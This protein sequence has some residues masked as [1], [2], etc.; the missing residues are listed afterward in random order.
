MIFLTR[1]PVKGNTT[2]ELIYFGKS[3]SA[4]DILIYV[5]EIGAL[6]TGDLFSRYG[7][8]GFGGTYTTDKKRWLNAHSWILKRTD[9]IETIIDGH[10]QIL[11]IDDLRS[12]NKSLLK[13]KGEEI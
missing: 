8:P 1:F 4:S 10:G 3:H 12:F 5:P 7:R 11:T 9:S 2:F 6:F 13:F